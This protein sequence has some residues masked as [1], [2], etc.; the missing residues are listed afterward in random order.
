MSFSMYH[1]LFQPIIKQFYIVVIKYYQTFYKNK[2]VFLLSPDGEEEGRN[3]HFL[4]T[5]HLYQYRVERGGKGGG[6]FF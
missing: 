3:S 6:K 1:M 5:L 2:Y 4:F